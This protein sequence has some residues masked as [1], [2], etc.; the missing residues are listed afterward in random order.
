[1]EVKVKITPFTKCTCG[2]ES[3]KHF[4]GRGSCYDCDCQKI[5]PLTPQLVKELEWIIQNF[6]SSK[7]PEQQLKWKN[8]LINW[9][10]AHPKEYESFL[11]DLI[12]TITGE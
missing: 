6:K 3:D 11:K 12:K 10:K 8:K 1:M 7:T 4:L 5:T 9:G 2:H